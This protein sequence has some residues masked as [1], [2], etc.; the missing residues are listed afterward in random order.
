MIPG[1]TPVHERVLEALAQP[2]VSHQYPAFVKAYKECLRRWTEI[3]RSAVGQPFVVSGSGT[4]A[5]EMALVNLVAPDQ[6]LLVVSHGFFGDRWEQIASSFGIECDVLRAEW[7]RAISAEELAA[8]LGRRDYA[9]VAVTHVDTSTGTRACLADYASLLEG[10][11]EHL[12]VDGVCATAG[13]EQRFDD[14]NI[15]VL[16]CGAQKAFGA[17]PGAAIL[18]VSQ[19]A[20]ETRINRASV[21]AYNADWLRWLPIMD[22]PSKYF[23]T[24]PV[25]LIL[26]INEAMG[27]VLEEGLDARFARHQE[28]AK[29]VRGG[30]AEMDLQLFTDA[31]CRAD[32]LSV[33]MHRDGVDDAAF[34]AAMAASGVV[35]AG[36]L[37]SIAGKAF[38]VGHMG[39]IG[40]TEIERTL[41]A[42]RQALG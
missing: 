26:A 2:T 7:G 14:W 6:R 32:T 23:S 31:S 29:L 1:P 37:G 25:N 28:M 8:G 33:V 12:I 41:D 5:M 21:P 24:P 27:L 16:L 30:L 4:F 11:T 3:G 38:R 40:P 20:M 10:R 34:R 39:N 15:D 19:R 42:I 13:I 35:V 36:A 17:P 22:D 18:L 9:A